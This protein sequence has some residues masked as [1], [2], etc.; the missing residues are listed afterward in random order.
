LFY[1]GDDDFVAAAVP[2]L[3]DG[4]LAREPTFVLVDQHK[5]DLL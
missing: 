5:I 1:A 2:F 4:A 3:R